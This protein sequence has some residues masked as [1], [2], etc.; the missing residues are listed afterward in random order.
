MQTQK[1]YCNTCESDEQHRRLTD[2]EKA[3]LKNFTRRKTVED[4]FMCTAPGCRNLRTGWDKR[5]FTPVLRVP[6]D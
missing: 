1:M 5:P 6:L 3:W 4:F 2:D